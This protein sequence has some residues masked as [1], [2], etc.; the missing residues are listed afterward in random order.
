MKRHEITVAK[1]AGFCFGVK[2]ATDMIA[3]KIAAHDGDR[4]FTLGKLIHNDTY[5]AQLAAD[6][7][8]ITSIEE[9][10]ALAKETENGRPVTVFVRAHGVTKQTSALL[11]SLSEKYQGFSYV[12][13]TCPYVKKIHRIAA[14]NCVP[15]N[16][17][18]EPIFVLIGAE[19]HPEVVGIVSYFE[20]RHFVYSTAAELGSA[21]ENKI[22]PNN[23]NI[24][25][26]VA[27][28]TTQKLTEWKN[29]LNIIK[30]VYTKAQIFDTIC[31]VT[32]IRQLEA[33]ELA[34]A[35]ETV[36]V[37]GG[38]DSSNTAKL[39]AI[40]S[41][42]C[43]NTICISEPQELEGS[44]PSI[45]QKVGIVAGA[46]TPGGIIEEVYNKMSEIKLDKAEISFDEMLDSAIKT[47]S[48]GDT[49]TGTVIAVNDVEI[50]LDLGAK[51]TG[52]LTADQI[53]DDAS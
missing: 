37:I 5:N 42:H 44:I 17:G 29:S 48:S 24:V 12:D 7:V 38:R 1:H 18:E 32:E 26:I 52:I 22:L 50:K 49:V 6:G 39:Y 19:S 4:I 13:C 10:E 33:E 35:C 34:K 36:I 28:Q 23:P 46:S 9:L 47:L 41:E 16:E 53:S 43:K 30:K 14:E 3:E 21:I 51:V 25:P 27:A 45:P 2:R 20:G 8:G 15:K 40:C 31:N 11:D